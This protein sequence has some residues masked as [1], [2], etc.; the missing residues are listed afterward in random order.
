[1]RLR[2]A[3]IAGVLL[4]LGAGRSAA[5]AEATPSI[6]DY[7]T[8]SWSEK[9]GLPSSY[10][11]S[12]VQDATGYLWVGTAAGL[13][14]FD[15]YRF[16]DWTSD[17]AVELP[18]LGIL[19]LCAA[20]DGSLWIS[21]SGSSNVG[22]LRDGK[23]TSFG[24]AD[25]LPDGSVQ[26][27]FEGRDGTIWAG[28]HGGLSQFRDGQWA[29]LGGRLGL[30]EPTVEGLFEDRAGQL[31]AGT[32]AGVFRQLGR[33]DAFEFFETA[34]RTAAR[35]FVEDDA[36]VIWTTDALRGFRHLNRGRAAAGTAPPR[37]TAVGYRLLSD[38][39]R[40]TWVATL[41]QGVLRVRSGDAGLTVERL[42]EA[43][44]LSGDTALCLFE[45]REKNIWIGTHQGLTRLSEAKIRAV[46]RRNADEPAATPSAV[47]ATPDGSVWIGT[48][49]GLIRFQEGRRTVF[50]RKAGLP[51][52]GVSALHADER[53][54]LW[55]AS[56]AGIV[57]HSQG[58][59]EPI[60]LP[61]EISLSRITA[62]AADSRGV[63][64]ICDFDKG[65]F[66]WQH[67]TMTAFE[68]PSDV[69]SNPG[70]AA[71][72]DRSQRI[73]IGFGAGTVGVLEGDRF[74]T[75]SRADGLPAG[76]IHGIY[77]DQQGRIWLAADDGLSRLDNGQFVTVTRANGLPKGRLFWVAG[78]Q[79]G[80]LWLWYTSG[81]VRLDATEFD[82]LAA[83]SAYRIQYIL[84][85][86]SDGLRG[87]PV[88]TGFPHVV[89]AR[90]GTL[91]F[92]TSGGAFVLDPRRLAEQ[93]EPPAIRIEA[94][95]TD[96]RR[97]AAVEGVRLPPRMSKLQ[98]DYAAL[99][100][101]APGKVRFR[102]RLDGVDSHWVD[103]GTNR[104][105]TYAHLGPGR[106]RFEVAA[107]SGNGRWGEPPAVWTFSVQPTFYQTRTFFISCAIL[108]GLLVW[109]VWQLRIRQI[110]REFSMVLAERAR[111]AREI[112]DTLLQSLVAMAVQL[113][114]VASELGPS[115]VS[116]KDDLGRFR[117]H[118]EDSIGEA[119]RSILDLRTPEALTRDLADTLRETAERVTSD[120]AVQFHYKVSGTPRPCSSRVQHQLSR[121]AHEAIVNAVRHARATRI[122]MELLYNRDSVRLRVVDDGC[123]FEPET[124]ARREGDHWGLTIMRERV[125]YL[126]GTLTV[127]SAPGCGATVEAETSLSA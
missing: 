63:L 36:G 30:P 106:Y 93:R 27:V 10:V 103:N 62:I 60:R 91:W 120:V 84:Y 3:A 4:V 125:E 88:Q 109:T 18:N 121:I 34:S 119:Q 15:G 43:T 72:R 19:D 46:L 17:T 50:G 32:S 22:R 100:L 29:R 8:A 20:R 56:A 38:Q 35:D 114:N 85:D 80:R 108:T 92:I 117:R 67:G 40:S 71:Y 75:Y 59:F 6:L 48:R 104:Q 65:L 33:S 87:T 5:A 78:D 123:G 99:S 95:V 127:T 116:V 41:G 28:G 47:E 73:W 24:P 13:V 12:V 79:E 76:R 113:D 98:I 77:E 82:R 124:A 102:H 83:N 101:T 111:V 94:V 44:G 81:L 74:R 68:T 39:R 25:G 107:H 16:T 7:T 115:L 86:A 31:W 21:F 53:G 23:L 1:M 69:G 122:R 64:W 126:G 58:R 14:R 57:R 61:P 110:Q 11:T 66:R 118:V 55:I 70:M 49:A 51:G 42:T 26:V 89:G 112:H 105:A 96:E 45:D 52:P 2:V 54:D 90:D 97:F 9:D 37:P